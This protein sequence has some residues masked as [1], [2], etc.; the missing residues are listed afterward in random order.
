MALLP[1]ASRPTVF[2][3]ASGTDGYTGLDREPAS[4]TADVAETPGFL[5]ELGRDWEA[6]AGQATGLDVRVVAV[7]TSFVLARESNLLR[8]LALPVRIG[9]GGRF[10]NGRQWFSWI[11]VDDLV[12]AYRLAIA[13]ARLVGPI[14]A[15]SPEPCRQRDLAA[16]LAR[17]LRRPCWLPVPAWLL[18]LVLRGQATLLL[19]SRRVVPTRLLGAGFSFLYG[20][21]EAALRDVLDRPS[22][23]RA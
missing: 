3:C 10:G 19:G 17:V 4:E 15:A 21:L 23:P 9:L 7:R 5:A 6:A 8:L 1:P 12:G 20:D 16:T 18:R 14:N 11:H 22:R 2:V 13:D